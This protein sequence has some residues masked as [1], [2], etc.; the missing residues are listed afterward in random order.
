[1]IIVYEVNQLNCFYDQ[2]KVL[3]DV[4]F[5][6]KKGEFLTILGP[7]GSGKTTLLKAMTGFLQPA[8]GTVKLQGKAL[9]QLSPEEIARK[10]ALVSQD[11]R[12]KFPF[13]C[14]EVVMMGRN[15]FQGCK[16]SNK[17]D[18]AIVHEAME[19][20]ETLK[21]ANTLITE[22]SMGE[23]QRVILARALAQ[24]PEVLFLDEAFSAM[25]VC[26]SIKSLN[27]LKKLVKEKNMTI[28]SVMHDLN[29]ADTYSDTV[30]ALNKGKIMRWGTAEKVMNPSFIHSL[31]KINVK[32]IGERG[33]AVL[34]QL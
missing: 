33:L 22:I 6:V 2:K 7:N 34:P 26:H 28:V 30:L 29:M 31:F 15:P 24:T 5:S 23:R 14:L 32:K 8:S 27:L 12:I 16:K 13:T 4:S 20:T 18:I 3:N 11:V 17:E 10:I 19:A 9:I 25:D 21:F 1:M